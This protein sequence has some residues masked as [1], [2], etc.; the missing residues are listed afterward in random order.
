[1]SFE[2]GFAGAKNIY[3]EVQNATVDSGWSLHGGWTVP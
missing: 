2:A 3:M 1:V